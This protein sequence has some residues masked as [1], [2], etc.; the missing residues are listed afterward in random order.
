[1]TMAQPPQGDARPPI[2]PPAQPDPAPAPEPGPPQPI[3]PPEPLPIPEPPHAAASVPTPV[4]DPE[5]VTYPPVG[6]YPGEPGH[7]D[8]EPAGSAQTSPASAGPVPGSAELTEWQHPMYPG[9]T[10]QPGDHGQWHPAPPPGSGQ[11]W[12]LAEHPPYEVPLVPTP[13]PAG[14]RR[15]ALWVS[16]AVAFTLLLC[17]GGALSAFLLLRNAENGKGAPDPATAVTRFLTAVYTEQDAKAANEL[18][19]REARDDKKITAKVDEV[20]RYAEEYSGPSFRWDEPTVASENDKRA[21]VAVAL[22]LTT[23]DEKSAQQDLT[24]TVVKKTGWWVC[25]VAG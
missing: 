14:S 9:E 5:T 13:A 7:P 23:T 11:P 21:L 25:E 22:T 4:A 6:A 18:V 19:C 8:E 17:G 12:P 10:W 24:F 15:T 3:P 20:K 1:M 16:L 2:G